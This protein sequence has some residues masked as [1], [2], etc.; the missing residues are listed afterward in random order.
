MSRSGLPDPVVTDAKTCLAEVFQMTRRI[1]RAFQS[2]WL[3][4][5]ESAQPLRVLDL[6]GDFATG[7][8]ASMAIH[9]G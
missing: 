3:S 2:P 9:T 5:F 7:M 8:G 1:D 6:A 4:V